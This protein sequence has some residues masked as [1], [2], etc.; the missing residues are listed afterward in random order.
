[1]HLSQAT[2]CKR[3]SC[4][5]GVLVHESRRQQLDSV[6]IDGHGGAG[7]AVDDVPAKQ[8]P[9]VLACTRMCTHAH[10]S[11]AEQGAT[12]RADAGMHQPA[13]AG[14]GCLHERAVF[15]LA[16]WLRAQR[17]SHPHR[18]PQQRRQSRCWMP[19]DLRVPGG[20]LCEDRGC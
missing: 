4:L 5:N 2:H 1:M 15:A 13:A 6:A 19:P 11:Y 18:Q 9:L 7:A 20:R 8:L 14:V 12:V 10:Q 16:Q 17:G 3:E